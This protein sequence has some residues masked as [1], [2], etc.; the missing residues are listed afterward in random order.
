M[1][2]AIT[3]SR[4]SIINVFSII[5]VTLINFNIHSNL[6]N[7]GTRLTIFYEREIQDSDRITWNK[8]FICIT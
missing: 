5:Y 1:A 8:A 4:T 6:I 2:M 7:V 3:Q